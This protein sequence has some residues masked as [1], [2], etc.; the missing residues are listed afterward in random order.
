MSII[1]RK[2]VT[3]SKTE[4]KAVENFIKA[5]PDGKAKATEEGKDRTPPKV[6]IPAAL[7]EDVDGKAVEF[8]IS[9][10]KFVK[11][12]LERALRLSKAELLL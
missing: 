12:A 6:A 11:L 10:A 5:A 7:L 4:I 3:Q 8:D 9:R 1:K 2:D